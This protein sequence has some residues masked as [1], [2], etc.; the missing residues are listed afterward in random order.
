MYILDE[1]INQINNN[2]KLSSFSSSFLSEDILRHAHHYF[3]YIIKN[4]STEIYILISD[5]PKELK[6]WIYT[7]KTDEIE[8]N[9]FKK[10]KEKELKTICRRHK[11]RYTCGSQSMEYMGHTAVIKYPRI[12]D[13]VSKKSIVLIPWFMF[14]RLKYPVFVYLFTYWQCKYVDRSEREAAA[15]AAVMFGTNIHFSVVSRSM[16]M[17]KALSEIEKEVPVSPP[18]HTDF[19]IDKIIEALPI[20]MT[21]DINGSQQ[22][23]SGGNSTVAL[24]NLSLL[25]T[26]VLHLEP[27]RTAKTTPPI[28]SGPRRKKAQG[29]GEDRGEKQAKPK[30]KILKEKIRANRA[31]QLFIILCRRIVLNAAIK[32]KKFLL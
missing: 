23:A 1:K 4:G 18:P 10:T 26:R 21:A 24:G 3:P 16:K 19:N 6:K 22:Q 29:D 32:Y 13:P 25:F 2:I 30:P 7:G 12:K 9:I 31:R 17:A 27:R 14:P 5:L 15:A 8:F 20:L 11:I 28:T